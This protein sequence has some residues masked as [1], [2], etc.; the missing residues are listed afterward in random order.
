MLT[1]CY[2]SDGLSQTM[3]QDGAVSLDTRHHY[4]LTDEERER[5]RRAFGSLT[6]TQATY[7]LQAALFITPLVL[8]NTTKVAHWAWNQTDMLQVCIDVDFLDAG[9]PHYISD[10]LTKDLGND[11]PPVIAQ[12]E[13][14]LLEGLLQIARGKDTSAGVLDK[15]VSAIPWNVLGN[16]DDTVTGWFSA[17]KHYIAQFVLKLMQPSTAL[18]PAPKDVDFLAVNLSA[19]I[20]AG[21]PFRDALLMETGGYSLQGE[22]IPNVEADRTIPSEDEDD[23]AA[24]AAGGQEA[25]DETP[26][27]PHTQG[28]QQCHSPCKL[29][30]KQ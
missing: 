27:V 20:P 5:L 17:C 30:L 7:P 26:S 21:L 24:S 3:Q 28:Q 2:H 15:F 22:F 13:L 8:L 4:Q 25:D 19:P 6:N 1:V 9:G 29:C 11:P 23:H 10:Q 18:R 16:L 12:L 14:L